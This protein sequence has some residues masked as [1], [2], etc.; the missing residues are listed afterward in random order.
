MRVSADF[1]EFRF[2]GLPA[3][4]SFQLVH[5]FQFVKLESTVARLHWAAALQDEFMDAYSKPGLYNFNWITFR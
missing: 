1:N 4:M 2:N 3:L 5:C